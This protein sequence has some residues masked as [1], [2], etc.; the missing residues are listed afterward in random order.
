MPG[1]R[2]LDAVVVGS[3]PNGLAAALTLARAGLCVTIFEQG[4]TIGGGTRSEPLTLPGFLH[5]VCSAVHPLGVA[6]PFFQSLPLEEYGL[7]WIHPEIQLAHPLDDGTAAL[8]D[9]GLE[10][11]ATALGSDAG[12]YRHL[13]APLVRDWPLL[14]PDLLAPCHF[15]QHPLPFALFGMRA[16][17]PAEL[18]GRMTFKTAGARALFAG[19][20]AHSFLPLNRPLSAAFGLILGALGHVAGWPVAKG[21]SRMIGE[22]M[23]LY[24]R[25]LGGEI[26]TGCAVASLDE[27]PAAPIVMLDLTP[28]QLLAL[29]G[30]RLPA[31]YRNRLQKYR[32]GPGVFKVDWALKAPIPWSAAGC[33]RAGTVHLG[34]SAQ[35]IAQGEKEVWQGMH[36]ERPFVLLAQPSLVDETRAPPGKQVGWAYCHVPNGS[37]V[38][39]SERIEAQVERFAPG[40]RG[41]ILARSTRNCAQYQSYNPNLIGGDINGGVQDLRQF[42][43]RPTLFSPYTTPI[44]GVYLCSSSTPP[45]GGVHGMCGYQAARQALRDRGA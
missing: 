13:M 31:A 6:S 29:G 17:L 40:F 8:L 7:Q 37:V 3:G 33:R 35:E 18:L 34:G 45:G 4:A 41:L 20:A 23:A 42:L 14:A 19:M 12:C 15:P 30:S 36:P 24:F 22:A 28:R 21:G 43:V 5:D 38:D 44:E 27:L 9:R 25:S 39:M 1:K 32:Y 2:T 11:T 10:E 26:V 16:A